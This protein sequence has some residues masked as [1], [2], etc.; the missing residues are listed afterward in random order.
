MGI[1]KPELHL[2]RRAAE[3]G[4][5]AHLRPLAMSRLS[6]SAVWHSRKMKCPNDG[7][8]PQVPSLNFSV[9][10]GWQELFPKSSSAWTA[11]PVKFYPDRVNQKPLG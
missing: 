2:P 10:P 6:P 9:G 5:F 11:S 7:A 1:S 8:H 3:K 4:R